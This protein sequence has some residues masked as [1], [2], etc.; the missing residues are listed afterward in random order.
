M[1]TGIH[2]LILYEQRVLYCLREFRNVCLNV[3]LWNHHLEYSEHHD[4]TSQFQVS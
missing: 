1:Q 4:K 2:V 3:N